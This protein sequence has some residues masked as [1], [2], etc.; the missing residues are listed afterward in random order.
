MSLLELIRSKGKE[1]GEIHCAEILGCTVEEFRSWFYKGKRRKEPSFS[2][3]QK[4][5]DLWMQSNGGLHKKS[6][7]D[8][9]TGSDVSYQSSNGTSVF[10]QKDVCLCIPI[11][12]AVEYEAFVSFMALIMKYK[13]SIRLELRGRDSM[14]ARSRN[15]LAKRFLK[16]GASWS[17][18]F[19][20]DMVVPF[21]HAGIFAATTGMT[22]LPD[23]FA[24]CHV[25]ERL[26]SWGKTIVGGCYWDRRGQ[27]RLIAG[28][29]QPILNPIPYDTLQ[30][31]NFNGTGCLAVHRKVFE[32]IIKKFPET[33]TETALGNEAGFFTPIQT[34]HRM[35]GEDEAFAWRANEAGHPSYIDLG[36]ICGHVGTVVHGIPLKGSKI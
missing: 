26:I 34:E 14:I 18:W 3:C 23:R 25:I 31:V 28:G 8:E 30:A 10:N 13:D 19:D 4:V 7:D 36:V 33:L 21:G 1:L 12:N 9:S 29:S 16:T 20:A 6:C 17:I 32:D 15:Q 27:G 5:I 24:G 11:Y 2:V 22:A 35:M